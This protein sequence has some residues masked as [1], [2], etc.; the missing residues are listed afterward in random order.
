M[1]SYSAYRSHK[2]LYYDQYTQTW[3][4]EYD[5]RNQDADNEM[6]T[7]GISEDED[8]NEL[9]GECGGTDSDSLQA[10]NLAH[11]TDAHDAD[12]QMEQ[13]EL[14]E[15]CISDSSTEH[16]GMYSYI[17]IYTCISCTCSYSYNIIY[18][19]V[20]IRISYTSYSL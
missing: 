12:E 10:D 11:L 13:D 14:F 6:H 18:T 1:L 17:Y 7:T 9:T 15:E 2:D 16:E 20:A 8:L 4:K 5:L 19:Y 3:V